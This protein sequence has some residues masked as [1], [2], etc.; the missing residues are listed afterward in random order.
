MYFAMSRGVSDYYSEEQQALL[1]KT[2]AAAGY[3]FGYD[4]D[5]DLNY[6][7]EAAPDKIS[8]KPA[9]NREV[10]QAFTAAGE[11]K[12]TDFFERILYLREL[13]KATMAKYEKFERWT[14]YTNIKVYLLPP[15]EG[16]I[17]VLQKEFLSIYPASSVASEKNR[18]E[19]AAKAEQS[20]ART[21]RPNIEEIIH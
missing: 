5:I 2:T 20:A 18:K 19:L 13:T 9:Y 14:E 7:F 1:E 4:E 8:A 16:Y 12:S 21:V 15:L 10:R 6:V 3:S 11:K 17:S